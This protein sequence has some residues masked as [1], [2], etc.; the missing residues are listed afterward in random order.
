MLYLT[1]EILVD[2][3]CSLDPYE[4]TYD[5]IMISAINMYSILKAL[6]K[7]VE[8]YLDCQMGHGLNNDGAGFQSDFG[9]GLTT[10]AEVNKYMVQR[11]LATSRLK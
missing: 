2:T 3:P 11:I 9:T 7:P 1:N 5:L 8:F 4:A 10:Q 6:E